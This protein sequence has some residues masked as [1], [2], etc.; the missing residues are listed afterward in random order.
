MITQQIQRGPNRRFVAQ[1]RSLAQWPDFIRAII[2]S[3]DEPWRPRRRDS[4]RLSPHQVPVVASGIDSAKAIKE[5]IKA[6][7]GNFLIG[8]FLAR[9]ADPGIQ[10]QSLIREG[11]L[12]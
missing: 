3:V 5:N 12:I 6:G 4:A 8:E 9:A 1:R 7:L 11:R 2:E 10:L